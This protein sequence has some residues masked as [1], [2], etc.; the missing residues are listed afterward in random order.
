M[1][2]GNATAEAIRAAQEVAT[3]AEP[4]DTKP[5]GS[6]R[7]ATQAQQLIELAE[8]AALF[9]AP[10]GT[11]YADLIVNGHRETVL[12]RSRTFRQW[13]ARSYYKATGGAVGTEALSAALNVLEAKAHFEAEERPVHVRVAGTG[14]RLYLD[15]GDETWQAVEIDE[16]GWRLVVDPPVRFRRPSGLRPLPHPERGGTIQA[17][18]RFL[19]VG[20]DGDFVLTIAWLV[21]CLRD[22]GPY[23]VLVLMGE[24]GSAKSTFSS[25]AR[26]LVDPNTAALRALPRDERDLF[27][28]ANNGHVLAFDNVSGLP[29]SVSDTLCRLAT[30]ASFAVRQL[31]SD[32]DETLFTASRPA[33]L[34]GIDDI[35]SRPDLADR[36]IF[37]TLSA[38]PEDKRRPETELW[39]A[40]ETEKPGLLGALLDAA[41]MALKRLSQTRLARTPRMADFAQWATA[42]EAAHWPDGTFMAAYDDNRADTVESVIDSDPVAA[43]VRTLLV[44]KR[45]WSG[46]ATDLL[47]TLG[48]VA[49]ERVEKSKAWPGDA[50]AL[51]SRLKR[52]AT[53]LRKVGIEVSFMRSGRNR[54]R[55]VQLASVASAPPAERGAAAVK[56]GG[57]DD[58]DDADADRAYRQEERA[59]IAQYDGGLSR[60]QAD[61]LAAGEFSDAAGSGE[62][63][64][65]LVEVPASASGR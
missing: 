52:A 54:T 23:P 14:G 28:A 44:D 2:N 21:A 39:A 10:D 12:L 30:G 26:S 32:Q 6:G 35:V 38:I 53:F 29:G 63:S 20:S 50:R 42:S 55:L 61:Q 1:T 37:L 13:L 36:A 7:S 58:A 16:T 34:N 60:A 48:D 8:G 57:E 45:E 41:A 33:I 15:L 62:A 19:N 25:M 24:Q 47:A 43:A 59:A 31:Y 40:F 11:A 3:A 4:G 46:T 65:D 22:R 5:T 9:H 56:T 27:I 49:G 51:S 17:L 18:R 64:P